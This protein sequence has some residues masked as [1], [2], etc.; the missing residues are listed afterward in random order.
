MVRQVRKT[1]PP[2]PLRTVQGPNPTLF[3]PEEI[4]D[5]PEHHDYARAMGLLTWGTWDAEARP[6]EE[7]LKDF[8]QAYPPDAPARFQGPMLVK[9]GAA[10]YGPAPG[11]SRFERIEALDNSFGTLG[12][13]L[14][15]Y[16]L[17]RRPAPSYVACEIE[18]S[19]F[20]EVTR[21]RNQRLR[22]LHGRVDIEAENM[23]EAKLAE[24]ERQEKNRAAEQIRAARQ[25][26]QR[27]APRGDG[28]RMTDGSPR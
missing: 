4:V 25:G 3:S 28:G 9:T 8:L 10:E 13:A 6:F 17:K 26:M 24:I 15:R 16:G 14:A 7:R 19:P 18:V 1:M 12:E 2:A 11:G 23:D 20:R 22:I 27:K 5:A 21:A